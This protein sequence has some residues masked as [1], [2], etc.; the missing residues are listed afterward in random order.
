MGDERSRKEMRGDHRTG[1][2][3]VRG[4]GSSSPLTRVNNWTGMDRHG[5]EGK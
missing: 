4:E 5:W 3:W 2:A 1:V